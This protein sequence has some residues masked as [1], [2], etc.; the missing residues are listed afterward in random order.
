M[1]HSNRSGGAAHLDELHLLLAHLQAAVARGQLERVDGVM[2][3]DSEAEQLTGVGN[4]FTAA[5]KV[6]DLGPNFVIIK[7][8]EHGAIL[9]HRDGTALVPAYPAGSDQVVDPTGA[10]DSFAGGFMAYL[11]RT[12]GRDFGAIQSALA[13]GTVTASFTLESFG[14]DGLKNLTID[15][16]EER[17]E[18]LRAAAR[19]G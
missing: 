2:I 7:K 10:G 17:V 16:L 19:I 13:W 5:R 4:P 8:G 3:N 1:A 15:Q 11:E 12:G 18:I 6:L 14:L 9:V